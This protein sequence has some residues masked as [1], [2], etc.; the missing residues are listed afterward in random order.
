[1]MLVIADNLARHHLCC[2]PETPAVTITN[3]QSFVPRLHSTPKDWG[4]CCKSRVVME[5]CV[6]DSAA[7]PLNRCGHS[8][9]HHRCP[10]N[11][12]LDSFIRLPFY[13]SRQ[14]TPVERHTTSSWLSAY[15]ANRPSHTLLIGYTAVTTHPRLTHLCTEG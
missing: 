7:G 12:I 14:K 6:P 11:F 2:F 15:L 8:F 13:L 9:C 3:G 10:Y 4:V 5:S 1:M